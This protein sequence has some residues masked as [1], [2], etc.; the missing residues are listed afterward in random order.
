MRRTFKN[1]P[2]EKFLKF[3]LSKFSQGRVADCWLLAAIHSL[4]NSDLGRKILSESVVDKGDY[5]RVFLKGV[6]T[7]YNIPKNVIKSHHNL[8]DGNL[9]VRAIEIA[10]AKY[11]RD[12]RFLLDFNYLLNDS[13]ELD[14]IYSIGFHKSKIGDLSYNYPKYAIFL[15][16]GFISLSYIHFFENSEQNEYEKIAKESKYFLSD[17]QFWEKIKLISENNSKFVVNF[18]FVSRDDFCDDTQTKFISGKRVFLNH[19]YSVA[20]IT[21]KEIVLVN[22]HD[23]KE[24]LTFDFAALNAFA[25]QVDI[26]ELEEGKVVALDFCEKFSFSLKYLIEY[27]FNFKFIYT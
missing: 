20:K 22:P 19:S 27:V 8:V 25:Y 3:N 16:T 10:I 2:F 5:I 18:G 14:L 7:V 26:T 6:S 24:Q 11:Q 13:A 21:N 23:T 9:D 1:N 17:L 12:N 15:L 4:M